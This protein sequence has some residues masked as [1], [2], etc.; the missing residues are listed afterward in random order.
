MLSEERRREIA[1]FLRAR[2][3]RVQPEEVGLPRGR[4]RRTPGLRREEVAS[5]AGVSTEWYKW[6]EQSREVRASAEVLRRIATALCLE[7]GESQHLLRLSGYHLEDETGG[8]RRPTEVSHHLRRL[9]GQLDYCPAWVLG[10]RYDILAWNEAAMVVAGDL[11]SMRGLERNAIYQLFLGRCMRETLVDWAYHARGMVGTLRAQYADSLDDPWFMELIELLL[12]R[13]PTFAKW[14]HNQDIRAYQ[15]GEKHYDH[16]EAG[17]LSFEFTALRVA[18]QRFAELSLITY[19]P[20]EGSGTRE[21][22]QQLLAARSAE[23]PEPQVAAS[24]R[25]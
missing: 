19:V 4:R 15:D 8:R 9:I 20:M 13:S 1:L 14:W 22:M 21:K 18:D 17:R 2:R 12:A 23:R 11:D 6:L 10:T 24:A 25:R 7:P 3:G 5:L 16:P